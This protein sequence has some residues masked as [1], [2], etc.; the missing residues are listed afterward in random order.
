MA[1]TT[2]NQTADRRTDRFQLR[3]FTADFKII[4]RT[5]FWK[6]NDLSDFHFPSFLHFQIK[7]PLVEVHQLRRL[8]RL[9]SLPAPQHHGCR[10]HR[11]NPG[12][13][14]TS[15]SLARDPESSVVW[16]SS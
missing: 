16:R 2:T 8:S 11:L 13:P 14:E 15:C 5:R 6:I 3:I 1:T 9:G 12:L 10:R 7:I 4:L